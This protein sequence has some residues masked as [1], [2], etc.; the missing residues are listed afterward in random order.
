METVPEAVELAELMAQI[1]RGLGRKM[2]ALLGDMSQPLG[3]AGATRWRWSRR[4]RRCRPR[5]ADFR[6]HCVDVAAEMLLIAE[7]VASPEEGRSR[8]ATLDDGPPGQV[9]VWIAAQGGD[10]HFV[11]DPARL[12]VG[13]ADRAVVRAPV[14]LC[15]PGDAA[16]SAT[17][18][19]I[20]AVDGRR[21]KTRLT[22]RGGRAGGKGKL[23][24]RV[25]AGEPLLWVHART[26]ET[27]ASAGAPGAC[28]RLRRACRRAAGGASGH[29]VRDG[30]EAN[31]WQAGDCYQTCNFPNLVLESGT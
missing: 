11:D 18:W 1:G 19:W 16:R 29:S 30:R 7:P 24:G 4:S 3:L 26:Q 9:P 21:R 28:L 13:A 14:R 8:A 15:R 25:D 20:W 27:L 2:T 31:A 5:P 22:R 10:L 6:Q 12:P 17:R 23:G